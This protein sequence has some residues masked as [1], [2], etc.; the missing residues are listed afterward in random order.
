MALRLV[1]SDIVH[2]VK[3]TCMCI[4]LTHFA[5]E[6]AQDDRSLLASLIASP[7]YAHDYASPFD[8][9]A[10][11]TE[12]AVHGRWWRSSIHPELFMPWMASDAESLFQDWADD[13]DWTDLASANRPR[14]NDA[15]RASTRYSDQVICTSWP[16]Q[17]PSTNTSTAP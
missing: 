9:A 14:S 6:T 4:Q 3:G 10:V 16:T 5:V 17:E 12:P 8:A 1:D 13:Q 11:V 7:A 2:L 15:Y